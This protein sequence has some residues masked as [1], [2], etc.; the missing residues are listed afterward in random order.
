MAKRGNKAVRQRERERLRDKER[1]RKREG[2]RERE[3]QRDREKVT[4]GEAERERERET[5]RLSG[6]KRGRQEKERERRIGPFHKQQLKSSA[7]PSGMWPQGYLPPGSGSAER[8]CNV[9][10]DTTGNQLG[11][12]TGALIRY[13][14]HPSCCVLAQRVLS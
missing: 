12:L 6:K 5:Q 13:S 4:Q 8:L 3:R 9:G 10:C 7:L 1:E 2:G 11:R 14:R